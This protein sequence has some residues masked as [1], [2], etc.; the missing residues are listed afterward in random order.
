MTRWSLVHGL[1]TLLIDG[2]LAPSAEKVPGTS[3]ELLI[4]AVLA[5]F[6]QA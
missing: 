2:R 6:V 5:R 1:S 3:V 4:E